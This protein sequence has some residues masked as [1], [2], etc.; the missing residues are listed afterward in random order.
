MAASVHLSGLPRIVPKNFST[1][2]C[3]RERKVDNLGP[4]GHCCH[5]GSGQKGRP[6]DSPRIWK[7]MEEK[8]EI[9]ALIL[10]SCSAD[11]KLRDLSVLD[12]GQKELCSN[13]SFSIKLVDQCREGV[14]SFSLLSNSTT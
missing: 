13:S 9:W 7:R 11:I 12:F 1:R 8:L 5:P 3:P 2:A 14:W 4:C 10:S 6:L